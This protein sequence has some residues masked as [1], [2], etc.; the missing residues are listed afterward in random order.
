M[1]DSAVKDALHPHLQA[2]ALMP[3]LALRQTVMT[4]RLTLPGQK[5]PALL[6]L[7]SW[8]RD[9]ASAKRA[10]L[11]RSC[12]LISG[13]GLTPAR[14]AVEAILKALG[15][16]AAKAHPL[17]TAL[18]RAGLA[19]GKYT[20]KLKMDLLP[21]MPAVI[22]ARLIL[23]RLLDIMR[24]NEEGIRQD[25]DSEF[26]HDFRVAVRR[27]R[28]VLMFFKPELAPDQPRSLKK[29]LR[30]VGN[31]TNTLRDLD[32]YLLKQSHY[33]QLLPVSMRPNIAP[34]FDFLSWQRRRVSKKVERFLASADYRQVMEIAQAFVAQEMETARPP[35]K[36]PPVSVGDVARR[37]IERFLEKTSQIWRQ[38]GHEIPDA[39]LHRLRIECKR[40]RYALEFFQSV[41]APGP[42]AEIIRQ[43][44]AVQDF[45]GNY[46]DSV[47]QRQFLFGFLRKMRVRNKVRL[48]ALAAALGVLIG[49]LSRE[50]EQMRAHLG[51]VF[52]EFYAPQNL[53]RFRQ[54]LRPS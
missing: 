50:K 7:E 51:D 47:V 5:S 38:E 19:P 31:A 34:V 18:E 35:H 53:E 48:A 6:V 37:E 10:P 23:K 3:R 36:V 49:A 46:Q 8:R 32:V 54:L 44:K 24:C 45:L 39:R 40:L 11:L 4:L 15:A 12:R 29:G 42:A 16:T 17:V 14:T 25:I 33:E 13:R 41:L 27:S 22:A 1:P 9:G 30:R 52:N 21:A 2:R 20:T 28:S 43:V 26:L